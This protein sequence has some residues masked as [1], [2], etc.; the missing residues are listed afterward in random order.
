ML[1]G[2]LK[3]MYDI[4][5]AKSGKSALSSVEKNTP[6]LILLDV[7]MPEMD[8]YEVCR[9]LKA[10]PKTSSIPIIFVTAM[11]HDKDEL[12]GFGLGAIDY[13]TKPVHP[14]VV[15]ARVSTHLV[16][17]EQKIELE[18]EVLEQTDE[19]DK[20]RRLIIQKLSM[21]AEYKDEATASHI[22]RMSKYCYEIA[23]SYGFNENE[24]NLML[25]AAPMHD[26]GKIGIPD[27]I[28]HKSDDMHSD[29]EKQILKEHCEIGAEI[30]GEP[31]SELLEIAGKIALQH[32]EN[33]DGTGYPKGLKGNEI[34][35]YARIASVSNRYDVLTHGI[36]NSKQMSKEEAREYINEHSGTE[37]DP[38]VVNAFNDVID[39]IFY[40][41]Q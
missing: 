22:L 29:E 5:V 24:S 40:Y 36:D 15:K 8:G 33:Y 1:N 18:K 21:A 39:T 20:T 14:S 41:N 34:N 16:L 27:E 35:I 9:I 3:P 4:Y 25:N 31:D 19:I 38:D 7:M 12:K 11:D 32:H 6:D 17:Q 37:F 30:L 2:I 26:I 10:D 28:V 13:L 23:K